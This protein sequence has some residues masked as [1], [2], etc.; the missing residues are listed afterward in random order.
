MS[1]NS[2]VILCL[3]ST[4]FSPVSPT[5]FFFFY[6]SW[7][8]VNSPFFFLSPYL[9]PKSFPPPFLI[10]AFDHTVE[11]RRIRGELKYIW[12]FFHQHHVSCCFLSCVLSLKF[13]SP[14]RPLGHR[15]Q[16]WITYQHRLCSVALSKEG[17]E[18]GM[19]GP[20]AR[21]SVCLQAPPATL[22]CS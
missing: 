16:L 15:G 4:S 12:V 11:N 20:R 6:H 5:R 8:P 2:I 10:S 17:G 13:T 18:G 1:L 14:L 9:N 3:L 22:I 21:G 19:E 7:N